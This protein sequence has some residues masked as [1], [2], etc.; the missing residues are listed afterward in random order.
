MLTIANDGQALKSTNYWDSAHAQE[1]LLYLSGN[2]GALRLLVPGPAE[3]MLA[4]MR[5][6][7]AVTIEPSGIT[8]GCYDVIFEDGS[9]SPFYVAIDRRQM[10]RKVEPGRD[11]PFI[12]YTQVGEQFRLQATVMA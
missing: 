3:D 6:G 9:S 2:A 4:E 1:G 8:P 7:T 5:T 11:V 10:D 12:I